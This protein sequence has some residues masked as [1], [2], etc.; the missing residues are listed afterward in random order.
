M[1]IFA[2]DIPPSIFDALARSSAWVT[3]DDAWRGILA[4]FPT[5][6][7]AYLHQLREAAAKRKGY[8]LLYA[9]REDRVQLLAL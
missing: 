2:V 5:A 8:I 9:L 6:N 3:D 7:D 1:P 4:G